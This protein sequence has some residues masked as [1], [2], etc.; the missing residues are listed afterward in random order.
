[1]ESG[2][3]E[4]GSDPNRLIG[5][6]L[7][8]SY[9]TA[10][11]WHSANRALSR[12]GIFA[13][14]RTAAGDETGYDLLVDQTEAQRARDL[15]GRDKMPENRMDQ[16]PNRGLSDRQQSTYAVWIILLWILM[17]M[18]VLLMGLLAISRVRPMKS[19]PPGIIR[20]ASVPFGAPL[21]SQREKSPESGNDAVR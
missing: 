7:V 5:W 1:M 18:V 9:R 11:Q 4:T 2:D 6:T 20:A 14:M 15:L 13:Q 8:N 3:V 19:R 16:P 17:G 12:H 21:A 10:G